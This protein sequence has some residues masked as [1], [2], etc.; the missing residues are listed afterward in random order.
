LKDINELPSIEEFEKMAGDLNE[1]IQ[2]E[3]PME[4][5]GSSSE[6]DSGRR[7]EDEPPH[8]IADDTIVDGRLSGLDPSYEEEDPSA[9]EAE[10]Q[11]SEKG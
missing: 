8:N 9:L 4:N 10:I 7:A 11:A 6:E 5:D 1:A 3:I 2:E